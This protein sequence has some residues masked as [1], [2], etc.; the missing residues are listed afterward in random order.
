MN[1]PDTGKAKV[2]LVEDHPMFRE[3]LAQLI[4]KDM[5]MHVAGEAGNI[6]DALRIIRATKPDI[7]I[8]DITLHGS[9]GLELIK[10]LKSE[11]IAVPVLVLSMH[12]EALYARRALRAGARGYITKDEDSSE[13]MAAI[14]Q[15]LAGGMYLSPQMTQKVLQDTAQSSAVKDVSGLGLLTDRELEVFR[16]FG[17]GQNTNEIATQLSLSE[18]TVSSYR[19]RI[20]EKLK[21]KN[22]TEIYSHAARWVRE[23]EQ[24]G[25]G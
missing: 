15:V 20:K 8:V 13:V 9:S 19:Q 24:Y 21:L 12:D 10:D 11:D 7:V 2:V 6:E 25:H 4:A 17:L 23:Q 16:L 1:K 3:R 5:A 22:F 14:R 18:N